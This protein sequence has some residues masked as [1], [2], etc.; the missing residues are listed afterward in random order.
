MAETKAVHAFDR[1]RQ[2]L[3]RVGALEMFDVDA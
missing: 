2:E 1:L 3:Q